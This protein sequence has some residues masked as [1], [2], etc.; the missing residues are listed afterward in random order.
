MMYARVLQAVSFMFGWL[1]RLRQSRETETITEAVTVANGRLTA[2]GVAEA[3]VL[4]ASPAVYDR[5]LLEGLPADER[6]LAEA[7]LA[8]ARS[9]SLELPTLPDLAIAVGRAVRD[10]DASIE[11]LAKLLQVDMLMSAKVVQAANSPAFGGYS[12]VSTLSQAIT[13]LGLRNTRDIVTSLAMRQMFSSERPALEQRMRQL[14]KSSTQ[15]AAVSAVLARFARGIDPERA[16]LA[17]LMHDVGVLAIIHYAAQQPE[18]AYSERQIESAIKHLRGFLGNTVLQ[19]WS[20]EQDLAQV[21]MCIASME[22]HIPGPIT[23]CDVVRVAK[24]HT[25][26]GRPELNEYP[27]LSELSAFRKFDLTTGGP[28]KSIE[29]L[30]E[31]KADIDAVL[32]TLNL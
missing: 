2:S 12:P 1:R 17:G 16:M 21:P 23:Y 32:Q 10:P 4:P 14:W 9:G 6:T 18:D 25:L 24:L 3:A 15:V 31:A 30:R 7:V 5:V 19:A 20:F 28:D 13:R 26:F 11:Q 8:A 29:A 27:P 22:E